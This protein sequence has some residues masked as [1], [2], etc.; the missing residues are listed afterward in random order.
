MENFR[1]EQPSINHKQLYNDMMDEW[2]K[3][4]G[5]LNPL[6]LKRDNVT[7]EKWLSWIEEDRYEKTCPKGSVPQELYFLI[8]N[9]NDKE[10]IVGAVTIR[11]IFIDKL[12]HNGSSFAYGIRPS[13]RQKGYG[14]M[15]LRL[16]IEKAYEIY[17]YKEFILTCDKSN[18]ESSKV[19]EA[20]GG[21]LESEKIDQNGNIILKYIIRLL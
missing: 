15:I 3:Y 16:A 21:V 8:K 12:G 19:I 9:E 14:K 2:E 1:L 4:G 5:R 10:Y 7:Y 20:N 13:E 6:A 18:I 11:K 17:L